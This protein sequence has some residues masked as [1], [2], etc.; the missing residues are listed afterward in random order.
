HAPPTQPTQPTPHAPHAPAAATI[1]RGGRN[2]MRMPAT[3]G[4]QLGLATA[5]QGGAGGDV[6]SSAFIAIG[7]MILVWFLLRM[8]WRRQG[9]AS[10]DGHEDAAR[11]GRQKTPLDHLASGSASRRPDREEEAAGAQLVQ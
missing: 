5:P 4:G 9:R 8:Q 6:L 10:S 2:R 7:V 3:A 1:G 11:A